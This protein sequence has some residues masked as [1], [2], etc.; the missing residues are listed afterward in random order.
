MEQQDTS[1]ESKQ[2]EE[3]TKKCDFRT[4]CLLCWRQIDL[5]LDRRGKPY[6][7][8]PGCGI[9]IFM[10]RTTIDDLKSYHQ[11]LV[12]TSKIVQDAMKKKKTLDEIKKAGL[13][14]KFK[15]AGSGFIK[16]DQWI[17]TI[18]KSYSRK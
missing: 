9:R 17:E 13:P 18:Y 4:F 16:T 2:Q 6:S 7:F 15:E 10:S 1:N 5:D 11:T 12:D 14:E 8:C 3:K